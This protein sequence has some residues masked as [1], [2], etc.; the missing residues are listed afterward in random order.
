MQSRP[1]WLE[2]MVCGQWQEVR[3]AFPLIFPGHLSIVM[4]LFVHGVFVHGGLFFASLKAGFKSQG[5][6][7]ARWPAWGVVP[8]RSGS[9]SFEVMS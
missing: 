8:T 6:L 7:Y 4:P 1:L 2:L 5:F 9:A 3:F